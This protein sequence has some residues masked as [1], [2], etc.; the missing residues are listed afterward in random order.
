MPQKRV[1][2]SFAASFARKKLNIS[3]LPRWIVK[4]TLYL[5]P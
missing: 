5:Q 1:D 3:F 4:K 2:S